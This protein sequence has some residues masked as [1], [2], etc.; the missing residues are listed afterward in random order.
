MNQTPSLHQFWAFTD[1]YV[2]FSEQEKDC[3]RPHLKL[4]ELPK[5]TTLVDLEA[6]SKEVFFIIKGCL[7]YYYLTDDGRE[8]TGFIFQENMFAGS[9]H[10]FFSQVPSTQILESIETTTVLSLSYTSLM[11]LY[12]LVPKM[13]ELVRKILEHR[14]AFAQSVIASLIINKPEERYRQ[15]LEQQPELVHRVPLHILATYIG[16]TPVSLSRIRARKTKKN[17]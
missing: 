9:H 5:Q 13:N 10:S 7:R 1:R 2:L 6:V 17:S 12:R 11:D 3:I 14:F 4:K 16:I 8:I 15:L